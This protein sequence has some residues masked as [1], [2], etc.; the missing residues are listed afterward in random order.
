MRRINRNEFYCGLL[1]MFF[2]VGTAAESLSYQVGTLAKMGPG[3]FPFALGILLSLLGGII[4][5]APSPE[6]AAERQPISRDQIRSWV[7]VTTG[8][9]AFII[10]GHYAGLVPATFMLVFISALGDRT[11]SVKAAMLLSTG[12][13][14]AAVVIFHYALQM[15][16]P[17]FRWS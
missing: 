4:M 10:L 16:F 5:V 8:L 3:Y 13:T 6:Q 14:L 2:G 17:L 15:Q 1:L 11:T 12:V 7:L 9:I